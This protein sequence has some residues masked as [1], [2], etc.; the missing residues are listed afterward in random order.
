MARDPPER[1]PA[2]LVRLLT[3]FSTEPEGQCKQNQFERR[4]R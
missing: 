2:A 3:P 4:L 1:R